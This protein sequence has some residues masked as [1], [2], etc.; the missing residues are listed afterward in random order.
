MTDKKEELVASRQWRSRQSDR[1]AQIDSYG[2]RALV[3]PTTGAHNSSRAAKLDRARHIL[4]ASDN[5]LEASFGLL[6]RAAPL[7]GMTPD[8][9]SPLL[10]LSGPL[11]FS[12]A[13]GAGSGI[14]GAGGQSSE[15]TPAP[16]SVPALQDEVACI[17]AQRL[18]RGETRLWIAQ[19]DDRARLPKRSRR[20]MLAP[21]HPDWLVALR[22]KQG[23]A[24]HGPEP[25]PP[26]PPMTDV[27]R[28]LEG[29]F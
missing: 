13:S 18:P 21:W 2:D 4:L 9:V 15:P 12:S 8:Q 24:G 11:L 7:R 25:P 19:R 22:A 23:P 27:Q 1:V 28:I 14:P 29:W 16:R 17:S 10:Q 3:C 20:F 26:P 5:E 6:C